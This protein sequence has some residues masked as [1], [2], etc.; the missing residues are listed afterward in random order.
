LSG[1][2][3]LVHSQTKNTDVHNLSRNGY[4]SL[5]VSLTLFDARTKKEAK[6]LRSRELCQNQQCQFCSKINKERILFFSIYVIRVFINVFIVLV[7]FEF[8]GGTKDKEMFMR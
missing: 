2:N 1:T 7:V 3:A 6:Y 8:S 4:D 5:P